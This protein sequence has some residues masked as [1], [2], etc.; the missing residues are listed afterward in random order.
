VT[1]NIEPDL[2]N[3]LTSFVDELMLA[4]KMKSLGGKYDDLLV[5]L[6]IARFE[7]HEGVREAEITERLV[8]AALISLF[9][10]EKNGRH[11]EGGA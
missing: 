7:K 6:G 3:T 1:P 5:E 11:E 8:I 4:S 10:D 9:E 2:R